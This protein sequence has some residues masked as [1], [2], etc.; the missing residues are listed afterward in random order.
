M[1]FLLLSHSCRVKILWQFHLLMVEVPDH[2][3]DPVGHILVN[4]ERPDLELHSISL[5]FP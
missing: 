1:G 2:C 4:G 5:I 3:T